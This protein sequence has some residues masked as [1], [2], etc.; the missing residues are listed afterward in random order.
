MPSTSFCEAE[1]SSSHGQLYA[2]A[3][4]RRSDQA[5]VNGSSRPWAHS[6]LHHQV[7]RG[8][9][10]PALPLWGLEAQTCLCLRTRRPHTSNAQTE[11]AVPRPLRMLVVP[12]CRGCYVRAGPPTPPALLLG[13]LCVELVSVQPSSQRHLTSAALVRRTACRKLQ[14]ALQPV[15]LRVSNDSHKHAGRAVPVCQCGQ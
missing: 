5:H 11:K 8:R 9:R 12:R 2:L 7:P 14:D 6:G 10:S 15:A 3:S 1:D 13:A 4:S